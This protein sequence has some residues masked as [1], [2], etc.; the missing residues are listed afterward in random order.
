MSLRP[1]SEVLRRYFQPG[2]PVERRLER[3][4]DQ[5]LH[6]LGAGARVLRDHLDQRRRRVG[7]GLD[8][9]V[10]AEWI[11]TAI[12]PIVPSRTIRRLCRLQEI[13]ARTML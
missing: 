3:D 7:I 1:A 12:R 8:V 9:E 2:H 5:P 13:R 10:E 6:L 11:P 4:A